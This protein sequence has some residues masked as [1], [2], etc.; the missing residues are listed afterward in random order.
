MSEPK[1]FYNANGDL[2]TLEIGDVIQISKKTKQMSFIRSLTKMNLACD[3]NELPVVC[4]TDD[5]ALINTMLVK[6]LLS[7]KGGFTLGHTQDNWIFIL[8]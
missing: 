2:T 8:R 3:H 1:I 5:E 4:K 6:N 7:F